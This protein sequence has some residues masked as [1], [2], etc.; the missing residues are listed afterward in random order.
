MSGDKLPPSFN[1]LKSNKP[2]GMLGTL[3]VTMG[4]ASSV[5]TSWKSTS[6]DKKIKIRQDSAEG[7]AAVSFV[8]TSPLKTLSTI[9]HQHD[10][11]KA[12][13][14]SEFNAIKSAVTSKFNCG[15]DARSSKQSKSCGIENISLTT[16][17]LNA[18]LGQQPSASSSA[19]LTSTGG[20]HLLSYYFDNIY[21]LIL[22]IHRLFPFHSE[23]C[24]NKR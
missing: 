4:M 12:Q 6:F 18:Q 9:N 15:L 13:E 24:D 20:K 19:L 7:V 21:E 2:G 14:T 8:A 23:L 1:F 10:Q 22:Y 11:R 16:T 5:V 17:A 3:A